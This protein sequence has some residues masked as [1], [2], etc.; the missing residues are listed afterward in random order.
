MTGSGNDLLWYL[1]KI[2]F[3]RPGEKDIAVI[4]TGDI[5]SVCR[6]RKHCHLDTLSKKNQQDLA[7]ASVWKF[8]YNNGCPR[9]RGGTL[10]TVDWG[11]EAKRKGSLTC[12]SSLP[13]KIRC[14]YWSSVSCSS[15][16][17]MVQLD[18]DALF[19]PD[20]HCQDTYI[21]GAGL[22]LL[23]QRLSRRVVLMS[24]HSWCLR[25]VPHLPP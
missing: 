12:L 3:V 21:L 24:L 20:P 14:C 22:W 19:A 4:K 15:S 13:N 7:T 11:S 16:R 6:D 5:S 23:W 25:L 8:R 1:S 18:P 17:H 10:T 9:T 2:E